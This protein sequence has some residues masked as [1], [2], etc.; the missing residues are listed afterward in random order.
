MKNGVQLD[1]RYVVP[2][3]IDLLVKYQS[4]LNVEWCNRSKAIKYLFKYINKGT[5]RVTAVLE[6]NVL[7]NSNDGME[8]ILEKDETKTYLDCGY[9]SASEAS[10]RIFQFEI[11]YHE[12]AVQRLNFHMKNE[13][14]VT[15]F[16]YEYLDN[17]VN[18]PG[19]EKTVFTEWMTANRLYEDARQLTFLDFPTKWVWDKKNKE[20]RRR[21]SG[22]SIGRI[23]YAHP[24]SGER[25]YLRML[26]NVVKGATSFDEIKTVNG[27]LC[28]SFKAACF[29][30]GLLDDS[31]GAS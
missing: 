27:Q 29:A 17:V 8:S 6:E 16:D 7:Y 14:Q 23:Y 24:S 2:Y 10:W 5:D 21:K 9:I 20:W 26:L 30:L 3:N 15:F 13:N 12:P 1:N 11:H 22:R 25:F 31:G 18:R 19:I 4:H 28:P